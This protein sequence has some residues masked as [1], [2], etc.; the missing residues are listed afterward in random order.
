MSTDTI[1][2][3]PIKKKESIDKVNDVSSDATKYTRKKQ[4]LCLIVGIPI[5]AILLEFFYRIYQ[6]SYQEQFK[7]KV[8]DIVSESKFLITRKCYDKLSLFG[9][10]SKQFGYR[11]MNCGE[12]ALIESHSPQ[13]R[14]SL[15]AVAD[16]VGGWAVQDV[17]PSE[18]AWTLMNFT[19]TVFQ[20]RF[21]NPKPS[22]NNIP[23][24]VEILNDAHNRIINEKKVIAGSST[25][26]VVIIDHCEKRLSAVNVGDSGFVILRNGKIHVHSKEH[27]RGYNFPFQLSPMF[28]TD[29]VLNGDKYEL[30]LLEN[31]I[32][33]IGTDGLFDNL[34]DKQ[35]LE[36]LDPLRD[37][38]ARKNLSFDEMNNRLSE[39]AQTLLYTCK[40][41]SMNTTWESPFSAYTGKFPGQLPHYGG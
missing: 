7:D 16:G 30:K 27:Q 4:I 10:P 34:Y 26:C 41:W 32:L 40:K 5:F 29:N 9:L 31:D 15:L 28:N 14:Y 25:A 6:T 22:N 19:A 8:K 18:F 33:L 35:I 39:Y 1:S 38:N 3:Q 11:I 21:V 20:E 13:G 37:K 2:E 12:D 36:I 17:D 24:P 23:P